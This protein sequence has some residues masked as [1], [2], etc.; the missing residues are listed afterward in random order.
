MCYTFCGEPCNTV[1]LHPRGHAQVAGGCAEQRSPALGSKGAPLARHTR[2]HVANVVVRLA[3]GGDPAI[4]HTAIEHLYLW[5]YRTHMQ[6]ADARG[7]GRAAPADR[8][9]ALKSNQN[10]LCRFTKR[11]MNR[12]DTFAS[13]SQC[14]ADRSTQRGSCCRPRQD[15]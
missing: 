5:I 11:T 4:Q 14:R 8:V 1:V 12:P 13:P 6:S 15:G 2:W 3:S 10:T 9:G 7:P